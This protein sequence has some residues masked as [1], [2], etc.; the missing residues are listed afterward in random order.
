MPVT[1]I[2]GS[3]MRL[4]LVDYTVGATVAT[5]LVNTSPTVRTIEGEALPD[6]D[7]LAAFLAEHGLH[8]GAAGADS[9]PPTADEVRRVHFLRREVRGVLETATE[10]HAVAGATV[11]LR[12]AG[13]APTLQRDAANRWQWH[14]PTV[15]GASLVDELAALVGAG[16]LGVIRTL[17]HERF[18][19]CQA[20]DCR[21]VFVDISRAGQRRYCMPDRCGNRLNVAN[22]RARR[23][24]TGMAR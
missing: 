3:A 21:G 4:P 22:H 17:G 12:R 11:L 18:R 1:M 13:L 14:I 15:A 8:R 2:G 6:P 5:D 9:F 24:I 19:A 16:L 7:A 10:D 23:Q 20:P